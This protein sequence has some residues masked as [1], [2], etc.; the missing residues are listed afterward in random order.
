M[1]EVRCQSC[2]MPMAAVE[3]F[4]TN[5]DASTSSDY[6]CF[7]YKNGAFTDNFTF[8]E[9]IDDSISNFYES[10]PAVE[11][12]LSSD[13]IILR[14][15]VR[16]QNLK[17]WRS[18]QKTHQEYYTAVNRA[19][20]YINNHLS[21]PINLSDLAGIANVSDFHFHRIFRAVMNESPGDYVQRLRLEKASFKLQAS[22][23]PLEDVADQTG[24]QTSQALVKAFKKR[25]GITPTQFRKQPLDFRIPLQ[26]PVKNMRVHP[27]IKSISPKEVISVRVVD[28]FNSA[29]AFQKAWKRLLDFVK[30]DGIP[31]QG[32]EYLCVSRDISTLTKP[33]NYRMYV[34][35]NS[36]Q[37]IKPKAQFS[38]QKI[39]GG[40]YA[41]FTHKGSYR[42]L[43]DLYCNIYRY[44]IPS[45]EYQLR[46]CL[47]FEKY[48][49][50]PEQ[51][52]EEELLTEIYIPVSKI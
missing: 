36:P 50:S 20:E 32:Y 51:V 31:S 22:T 43:S 9:F 16:L 40:L 48:L 27:E 39:E 18:H 25:Y 33:D 13:E 15:R 5:S 3:H 14:E 7:C 26:H 46:D 8:D 49:N 38:I 42:N 23:L 37:H 35:I 21:E 17:R 44:W 1:K 4:G 12:N 24:Y 2:G 34:C 28:P 45:S 29:D 10:D 6:C 41:V 47:Q 52:K 30:L 19:V 11:H